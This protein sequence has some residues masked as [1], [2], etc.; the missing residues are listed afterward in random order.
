VSNLD[1][2]LLNWQKKVWQHP[3]RFQIVA[4]GRR[5][6][7]S[8]LAASKLLVKGLEATSG[9]VFYVAPTQGQ[10]R[11]IMWQ[12]LLEMGHNVIK[13]VHVNN[14]EITLI[15]GIKIRLKG[16]DRPETMRGVSLYYL[17]LD[18]YADIRPDVWEQI[19][20]PA[21]ADLK[22]EALFI[23]T[24]MGRNHFYDLFKYAELSEDADWKS[25]HFTSYDNETLD[26][27]EIEAAKRSMSSYAFRQEFMASFESLG[28]EIFKDE[29]I[30]YGEEPDIGDYYITIDLAGFREVGKARS[31][32]S[33][34]DESAISV[35]K[36][37]PSGDWWIANIIRG[38]WELGQ[39][40]EKI[41][42]A[43]RDYHP[44]AV[45]LE[46]GISRQAV[47]SPLTDLMRR[48]NFYFN[49][50]EL[51]HGNQK[52]IDRIVWALQGRFEN[53]RVTLNRGEWNE[54]LLDQLFQFPNELVHDDLV[55]A[56]AYIDQLADVP[57]GIDDFQDHSYEP[58]DI[59]SGY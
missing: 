39:T 49:V 38:R 25:W 16:A 44:V 32:N 29:W 14:L 21:L 6:G 2:R 46:R 48:Y 7:K 23:G 31:K 50:K 20:R 42:Q 37:T 8:R 56:L 12:L 11:D 19:L 52:K 10:A 9:T 30:K 36:V 57:Y 13:G 53:G 22:G 47:M 17:V 45:G 51:T 1:I 26:P 35:V 41:F 5:C 54:Q 15:N 28:S 18:E 27:K 40:A 59:L 55:D 43:V 4:A 3:S 24:P 34:L 58:I 33:R